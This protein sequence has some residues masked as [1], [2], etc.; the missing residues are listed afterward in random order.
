M[1]FQ[2]TVLYCRGA[3]TL[4]LLHDSQIEYENFDKKKLLFFIEDI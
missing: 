4:R 1:K 2:E 3:H